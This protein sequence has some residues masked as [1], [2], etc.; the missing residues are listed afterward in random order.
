MS[1]YNALD[2]IGSR[3]HSTDK[4][5]SRAHDT[6]P[7]WDPGKQDRRAYLASS[8]GYYRKDHKNPHSIKIERMSEMSSSIMITP[9]IS[10]QEIF[11]QFSYR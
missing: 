10:R 3:V 11:K 1:A 7:S 8:S 5:G 4:I 9:N 6:S 2:I